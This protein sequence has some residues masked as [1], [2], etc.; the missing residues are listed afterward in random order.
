[1]DSTARRF[2]TSTGKGDDMHVISYGFSTDLVPPKTTT[3]APNEPT[4]KKILPAFMASMRRDGAFVECRRAVVLS[5]DPKVEQCDAILLA[6]LQRCNMKIRN[7]YLKAGIPVII[8]DAAPILRDKLFRPLW[9]DSLNWL[10]PD[11]GDHA[12]AVRLGIIAKRDRSP[13]PR[14]ALIVGQKPGDAAHGIKDITR[15]AEKQVAAIK[16]RFP[17]VP[18]RF[19]SH[20]KYKCHPGGCEVEHAEQKPLDQSLRE[21]LFVW[22]HNS[23]AAWQAFR[24]CVPVYSDPCAVYAPIADGR[25]ITPEIAQPWLDRLV[26]PLFLPYEFADGTAWNYIRP[27][28]SRKRAAHLDAMHGYSHLDHQE[29]MPCH[30]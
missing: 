23:T 10:P 14:H 2:T 7:A 20:P 8:H 1:M 27:Y 28:A 24:Q 17:G 15:W 19:R 16:E 4:M 26:A 6:G 21:A 29:A 12:K 11:A 3:C 25:D 13:S 5:G 30:P 18:I 9:I 22:T